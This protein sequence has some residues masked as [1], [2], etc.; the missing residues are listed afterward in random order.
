MTKE[1]K[2]SLKDSI[3]V[4]LLKVVFSIYLSI[5]VVITC[6]QMLH[7]YSQEEKEVL[8]ALERAEYIFK[9]NLVNALWNFDEEQIYANEQGIMHVPS[10]VGMRVH[11]IVQDKYIAH[12]GF[13]L[14]RE[15]EI[16]HSEGEKPSAYLRLFM[17]K[18]SLVHDNKRIGEAVLYSSNKVVFDKVKSYFLVIIFTAIIKII[19]LWGL[20]LW[21]FNKFLTKPLDL[22]C[23]AME[24]IDLDKP[25]ET[26]LSLET[27]NIY[28][29]SRLEYMFN[30][31]RRRISDSLERQDLLNRT[32]EEQ[33]D[34]RTKELQK[35]NQQLESTNRMLEKYVILIEKN[36][37]TDELTALYNRRYFN[38]VFPEKIALALSTGRSIAFMMIDVDYFKKYNDNY[39]HQKGD[40][41][42]A[43]IGKVIKANCQRSD[44]VPLRL[45]GE[46]FGIIFLGADCQQC[47]NFS[48]R[49]RTFIEKLDIEHAF[50]GDVGHITVSCGVVTG[51]N[52]TPEIDMD[53]LYR[54]ADEALYIAKKNGR[55]QIKQIEL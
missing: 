35:S 17:R 39:G 32:L 4:R 14:N 13:A 12:A 23:H 45:G 43:A 48:E 28:E 30:T 46:E 2:Y 29:L 50:N 1:A 33:V 16:V 22:F 31:M 51:D 44:D 36:A 27:F 15:G 18:F 41:A 54:L 53:E 3:A 10:I 52:L 26:S 25:A 49:I 34:T 19:M 42:L 55:N 21:A 6:M 38:Q 40:E 37:I 7:E 8:L 11:D 20:F 9:A 24:R 5:T 47:K